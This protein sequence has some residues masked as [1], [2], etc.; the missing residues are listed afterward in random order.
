MI[1]VAEGALVEFEG[2][3]NPEE[4]HERLLEMLDSDKLLHRHAC[5][6]A[7]PKLI[8]GISEQVRVVDGEW[9]VVPLRDAQVIEAELLGES[10]RLVR[11]VVLTV[12]IHRLRTVGTAWSR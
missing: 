12:R 4:V 6:L 3:E 10:Q 11:K 2:H 5:R 9:K 1:H 7:Q 8:E